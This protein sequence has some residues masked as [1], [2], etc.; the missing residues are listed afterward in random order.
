MTATIDRMPPGANRLNPMLITD[1]LYRARLYADIRN[2]TPYR[3]ASYW[4]E[5][6]VSPGERLM[7]ELIAVR[8][9]NDESLKWAV[10][11]AAELDDSRREI[12][13]GITLNL[14]SRD[15]IR[16]RIKVYQRMTAIA[17][18]KATLTRIGRSAP[19]EPVEPPPPPTG[20]SGFENEL[21]EALLALGQ[22]SPTVLPSDLLNEQTLN[23]QAK[24][25]DERLAKLKALLEV[26]RNG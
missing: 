2:Q 16:D 26:W 9:W 3:G 7:P 25:T 12:E 21:M 17:L 24:A 11:V 22:P 10:M 4:S 19:V 14:P 23:K 15:W 18:P 1:P 13:S 20:S 8:V 5:H 6:V